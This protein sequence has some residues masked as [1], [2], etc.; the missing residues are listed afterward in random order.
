MRY[1]LCLWVSTPVHTWGVVIRG[2]LV[3]LPGSRPP[4]RQDGPSTPVFGTP[5]PRKVGLTEW[6]GISALALV[7]GYVFNAAAVGRPAWLDFR[8]HAKHRG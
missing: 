3:L 8:R 4:Q 2:G 7:P 5:R 6:R 1:S